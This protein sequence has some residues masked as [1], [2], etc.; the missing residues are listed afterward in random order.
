[1]YTSSNKLHLITQSDLNNSIFVLKKYNENLRFFFNI[2]YKILTVS[3]VYL[4][5]QPPT[6][7][8]KLELIN[9]FLK[10]L[11]KESKF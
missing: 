11:E 5:I 7:H 9:Q 4:V 6:Q 8:T 10:T 3:G 2:Q 1:M